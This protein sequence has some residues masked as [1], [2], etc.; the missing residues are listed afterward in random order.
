MKPDYFYLFYP[1]NGCNG[2]LVCIYNK[3]DVASKAYESDDIEKR[4]FGRH[5]GKKRSD[6]GE[7]SYEPTQWKRTE[8]GYIISG[9]LSDG[10]PFGFHGFICS[11]FW[12]ES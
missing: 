3:L 7:N 5:G 1:G 6:I 12:G 2:S 10:D 8:V 11:L 4:M 9:L